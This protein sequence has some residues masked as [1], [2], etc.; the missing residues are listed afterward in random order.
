MEKVDICGSH[1]AG[2]TSTV[3]PH[4]ESAMIAERRI[5]FFIGNLPAKE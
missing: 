4:A 2:G 1:G 5:V 3:V